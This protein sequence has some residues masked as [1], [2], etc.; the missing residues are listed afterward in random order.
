M[1][2]STILGIGVDEGMVT[3]I[4]DSLGCEVE[5]WPTKYLG[6]P[7]GGNL[8]RGDF[9]EPVINKVA[10]KLA[11]WKKSVFVERREI[12]SYR[13][14]AFNNSYLLSFVI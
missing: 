3:S 2:K 4:A 5:S 12:D 14:S 7:L 10:K 13:G 1:S 11:G 8:C 6:M 9:W